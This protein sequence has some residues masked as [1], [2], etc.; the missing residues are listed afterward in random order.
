MYGLTFFEISQVFIFIILS[1]II[2]RKKTE[3]LTLSDKDMIPIGY[4]IGGIVLLP[5]I[6]A[7]FGAIKYSIRGD[8]ISWGLLLGSFVVG[9][10]GILMIYYSHKTKKESSATKGKTRKTISKKQKRFWM[11]YFL[12]FVIIT[13]LLRYILKL[14]EFTLI[15]ISAYIILIIALYFFLRIIFSKKKYNAQTERVIH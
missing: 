9:I 1:W 5:A 2:F 7:L 3:Y 12:I 15:T 14:T 8:P 13:A 10:L 4:T 6:I 11:I